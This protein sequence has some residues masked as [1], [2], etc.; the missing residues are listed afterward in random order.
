MKSLQ[1]TKGKTLTILLS[2]LEQTVYE[3]KSASG[4]LEESKVEEVRRK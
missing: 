4:K 3:V 1:Y 2:E